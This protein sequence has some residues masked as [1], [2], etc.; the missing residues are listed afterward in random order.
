MELKNYSNFLVHL[1]IY[2]ETILYRTYYENLFCLYSFFV[3]H[4]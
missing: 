2:I 3:G 4:I 1:K